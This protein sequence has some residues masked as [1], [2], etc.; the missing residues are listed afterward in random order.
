MNS[1]V[2][3]VQ[4]SGGWNLMLTKSQ[5]TMNI[6]RNPNL[7]LVLCAYEKALLQIVTL[8]GSS[9]WRERKD[10]A[11]N[12]SPSKN[13]IKPWYV[14]LVSR[15]GFSPDSHIFVAPACCSQAVCQIVFE[16]NWIEKAQDGR[17]SKD[18]FFQFLRSDLPFLRSRAGL[19]IPRNPF[20]QRVAF[21][22]FH[23]RR[24]HLNSA[25]F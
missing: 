16:L 2:I 23:P 1:Q 14:P 9:D 5:I 6:Y 10:S 15:L 4:L 20:L 11:R 25:S 21:C 19:W 24:N 8:S 13:K 18:Q 12:H 7:I 17:G 3:N 22:K